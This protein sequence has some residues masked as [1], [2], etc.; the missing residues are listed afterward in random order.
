MR[1]IKF[2]MIIMVLAGVSSC[3]KFLDDEPT[4]SLTPESN[5]TS[6]T[7]ARAFANSAYS[8]LTVLDQGSGGYGGNTASLMEFMSGKASGNAQTE[9]FRFYQLTYD[10]QSFYINTWWQGLYR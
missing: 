1:S 5:V 6:P 3:S 10:A 9:S 8:A 2:L 4:G 7:I